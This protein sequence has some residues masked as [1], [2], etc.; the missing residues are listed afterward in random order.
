MMAIY[1]LTWRSDLAHADHGSNT[2]PNLPELAAKTRPPGNR[3]SD[4]DRHSCVGNRSIQKGDRVFLLKQCQ[5]SW[6]V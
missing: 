5:F 1:L 4:M 2:W 3:F 6:K